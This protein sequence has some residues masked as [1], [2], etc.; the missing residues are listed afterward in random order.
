MYVSQHVVPVAHRLAF[1]LA[2][3][4]NNLTTSSKT[5]LTYLDVTH[6]S[7]RKQ[8][9]CYFKG[10]SLLFKSVLQ[11]SPALSFFFLRQ[12][13]WSFECEEDAQIG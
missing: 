12:F 6:T 1:H 2:V 11:E 7:H 5:V 4:C 13:L 9:F 10:I 3:C 8:A